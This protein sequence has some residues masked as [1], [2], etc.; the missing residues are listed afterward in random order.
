MVDKLA[1]GIQGSSPCVSD[2][3]EFFDT[4]DFS[5]SSVGRYCSLEAPE[6][7]VIASGGARIVFQ[8]RANRNRGPEYVGARVSYTVL[9]KL[10]TSVI[11]SSYIIM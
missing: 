9:G 10:I 3:L 1:F 8:G 2:Y 11:V 6:P 7:V 5:G 4:A